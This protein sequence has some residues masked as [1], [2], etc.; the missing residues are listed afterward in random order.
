MLCKQQHWMGFPQ[1][2]RLSEFLL[3]LIFLWMFS[4]PVSAENQQQEKFTLSGLITDAENGD[5]LIGASIIIKGSG[6]GTAADM[7]GRYQLELSRLEGTLVVSYLGYTTTEVQIRN[8]SIVNVAL[9]TSEMTRLDEVQ[10]VAYG[11]QKK[12]TMTGAISSVGGDQLIKI[13]TGNIGNMLAGMMTGVSSV[14][15]SGQPG[16]DDPDL[17]VRGVQGLNTAT[18]KPLCLVDGVERSFNQLDPNEIESITVLKDASSTAVFGVRGANGVIL[19]T[20]KRGKTGKVSISGSGSYSIQYPTRMP[21]FADSYTYALYHNE[22]NTND[23]RMG[24]FM[25]DVVEGFRTG[26]NPLVY[27]NTDFMKMLFKSS[28]PQAQ[29]NVNISGGSEKVRYFVSVGLFNQ[30]GFFKNIDP[31]VDANYNYNR[32]NYRSNLDVDFT[33]TTSMSLNVGGRVE[34][35]DSPRTLHDANQLFRF[36]YRGTPFSGSGIV[37]GKWITANSLYIPI[38]VSDPLYQFVGRGYDNK[39]TNALNFDIGLTQKL[40]FITKNLKFRIKGAYNNWADHIKSRGTSIE[41][42]VPYRK[43]DVTGIG[44]IPPGEEDDLVFIQQNEEGLVGYGE[45]R[46]AGRDWYAEAGFEWNRS[47]NR[48]HNMTALLLYNQ[49]KYYY[50]N[51]NFSSIPHG[52]VGLVGRVTY[53]YETKYLAEFNVGYNG[54]ENFNTKKRYDWFPAI[55]LGWILTEESFLKDNEILTNLKLRASYGKVGQDDYHPNNDDYTVRFLYLPDSYSLGSGAQFG[56]GDSWTNGAYENSLGKWDIGWAVSHKQNYGIDFG[57][58]KQRLSGSIDAFYEHRTRILARRQTAPIIVGIA[59]PVDNIGIV[60]NRGVELNLKWM[61][62]INEFRY[63]ANLNLSYAKNEIVY[64]DEVQ[65]EYEYTMQTGRP[66]GQ[67]YGFKVKG[68]YYEGMEGVAD[69]NYELQPGDVAFEDLNGDGK[70]DDN[71]KTALGYPNYPLLNAGLSL[72]FEWKGFDFSMLIVGATFT[73]RE[74]TE[75]FRDPVGVNL[76][77]PLLQF[78]YDRRWT[79]PES[80]NSETLPRASFNGVSNNTR[81]SEL[82]I[83]DASYLRLKNVEIGYN[84]KANFMRSLGMEKLRV[85]ANGYNLFTVDKLKIS[86]PESLGSGAPQYPV[87]SVVNFGLNVVF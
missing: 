52:Y 1:I 23:G 2:F 71:D 4:L 55:S 27:P 18:S 43:K 13:P 46:N 50:P 85:F 15:N 75:T 8:R 40:D 36:I 86:D 87:M 6:I 58:L 72:G 67:R 19:V 38:E 14:Q 60:D 84:F 21:E 47:F 63:W 17:F 11:V 66:V 64:M 30:E 78:Q 35:K 54:S 82:F 41:N 3:M 44:V 10:V 74:L 39:T 33:K 25:P 70:I 22:C 73:S 68:F 7:D 76:S 12:V 48:K 57:F 24:V 49:S 62:R 5:A 9:P 61:D 16:G 65:S 45:S 80:V 53:D 20:T 59:L 81:T 32:Y 51:S 83:K 69:H 77:G 34:T 42:Y 37:D 56:T 79:S 26:S 31:R 29:G 28:A